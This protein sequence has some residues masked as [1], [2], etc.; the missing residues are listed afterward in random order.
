[1]VF[2]S[3]HLYFNIF[4]QKSIDILKKMLYNEAKVGRGD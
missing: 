2:K 4:F 3:S 1:M